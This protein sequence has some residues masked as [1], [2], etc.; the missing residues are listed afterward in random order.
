VVSALQAG[1]AGASKPA[2]EH[3]VVSDDDF[4]DDQSEGM[5]EV[6]VLATASCAIDQLV[7]AKGL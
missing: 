3:P 5:C 4:R 1:F 7:R 6:V 2:G